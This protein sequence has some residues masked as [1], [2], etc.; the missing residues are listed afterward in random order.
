MLYLAKNSTNRLSVDAPI[1]AVLST[2]YYYFTFS[3]LQTQD[4]FSSYLTRLN[5]ASTRY[6]EFDLI[7]PTDLN[8]TSGAYQYK[9]YENAAEVGTD[10]SLMSLLEQGMCKV[11]K[12]FTPGTYY[13]P[14]T[15]ISPTY[16]N[17]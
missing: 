12:S 13:E 6:G 14:P 2:P 5:P 17:S 4:F 7:L 3:H 16:G 15:L 8:M 10:T 1:M 9:I 11:A